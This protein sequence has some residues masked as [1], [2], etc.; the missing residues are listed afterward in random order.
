MKC[1]KN[2][3]VCMSIRSYKF[4]ILAI[5]KVPDSNV[6]NYGIKLFK[7][8]ALPVINITQSVSSI[9]MEYCIN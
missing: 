8:D 6:T 4:H 9:H 7:R 2:T 5:V 3:F 1:C